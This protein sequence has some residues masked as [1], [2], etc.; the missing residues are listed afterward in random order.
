MVELPVVRSTTLAAPVIA[1]A[2]IAAGS[3]GAAA[4][5]PGSRHL[6]R[7]GPGPAAAGAGPSDEV[8]TEFLLPRSGVA[9]G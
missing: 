2:A 8:C 1:H 4:S 3:V 5:R 6:R 9:V 7:P